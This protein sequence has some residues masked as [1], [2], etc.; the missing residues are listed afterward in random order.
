MN[1]RMSPEKRYYKFTKINIRYKM[2][3]CYKNDQFRYISVN[4]H[5]YRFLV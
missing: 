3:K 4:I 5:L 2:I 1:E